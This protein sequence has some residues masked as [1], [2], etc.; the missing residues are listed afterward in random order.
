MP[1]PEITKQKVFFGPGDFLIKTVKTWHCQT[2]GRAIGQAY[3]LHGWDYHGEII[4]PDCLHASRQV[5][6]DEL[7]I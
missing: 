7:T 5:M 1:E 4:C 6:S 2:C 3:A